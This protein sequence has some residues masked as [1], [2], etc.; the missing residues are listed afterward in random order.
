MFP[1]DSALLVFLTV[2]EKESG[3]GID[4]WRGC[5]ITGKPFRSMSI[6]QFSTQCHF[7]LDV[8]SLNFKRVGSAKSGNLFINI[9]KYK[10]STPHICSY[11]NF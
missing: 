3:R 6:D 2:C 8:I 5:R 11:G 4:D 10:Q 9:L 1:L 7:F